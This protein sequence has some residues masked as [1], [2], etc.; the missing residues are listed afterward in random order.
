MFKHKIFCIFRIAILEIYANNYV[1]SYSY[2]YERYNIYF[3]FDIHAVSHT[4][5]TSVDHRLYTIVTFPY[6]YFFVISD[7]SNHRISAI[8]L[9]FKK[10]S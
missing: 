3:K 9:L 2:Y 8:K 7:E 1:Q 10:R 4:F 6:Q 5:K